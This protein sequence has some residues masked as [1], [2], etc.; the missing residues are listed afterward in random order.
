VTGAQSWRA[1][2]SYDRHNVL[3]TELALRWAE[4]ADIGTVLGERFSTHDLLAGTGLGRDE[5]PSEASADFTVVRPDGMRIA[6]ELTAHATRGLSG[7]IRRWVRLLHERPFETSGLCVVFVAAPHPQLLADS[8]G[9]R[10]RTAIYK[11]INAARKEFP[12][13]Q[14]DRVAERI[15][16]ASWREWFPAPGHVTE[17]FLAM[18]VDRPTGR[19]ENVWEPCDMLDPAGRPFQPAEDFDATAVFDNSA[20]LGQTPCWLREKYTPPQLWEMMLEKA[21]VAHL[22]TAATPLPHMLGLG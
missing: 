9:R 19:D 1:P 11:Q 5:I 15:G 3:A 20:L 7:K 6:V 17:A 21:G 18:Q 14:G 12:G 22:H 10:A 16:V 13:R 4:Y 8:K 2:T